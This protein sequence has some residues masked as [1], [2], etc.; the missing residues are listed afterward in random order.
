MA[1]WRDGPGVAVPERLARFVPSEWSGD[2]PLGQWKASCLA[3]LEANP[4]RR[5]PF[6]AYGGP[7][8]VLREVYRVKHAGW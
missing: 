6:G 5:L 7:I 8:D 1:R 2:D 3:W 4:G